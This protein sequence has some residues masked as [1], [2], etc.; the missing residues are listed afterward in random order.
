MAES[1]CC[2]SHAPRALENFQSPGAQGCS[3]R[4]VSS[5]CRSQ[6]V[7]LTGK[8]REQEQWPL[9]LCM[10]ALYVITTLLPSIVRTVLPCDS[11]GSGSSS[12]WS[13]QPWSQVVRGRGRIVIQ[14]CP[15]SQPPS[16][17]SL[18]PSCFLFFI[19]IINTPRAR[20][21]IANIKPQAWPLILWAQIHTSRK[22]KRKLWSIY[23]DENQRLMDNHIGVFLFL[24]SFLCFGHSTQYA[25]SY[26]PDPESNSWSLQWKLRVW[27]M[28]PRG[29]S[30]T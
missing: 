24:F 19:L 22:R 27:S 5:W 25:G 7:Y 18:L 6:S 26:F 21:P 20:A 1:I 14:T 2:D 11:W 29:N 8:R 28:E 15:S 30:L 23:M 9:A 4:R 10:S 16:F 17:L 12:I 3:H 13:H